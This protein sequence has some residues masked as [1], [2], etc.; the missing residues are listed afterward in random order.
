MNLRWHARFCLVLWMTVVAA[1]SPWTVAGHEGLHR[2]GLVVRH[3]DGRLTYVYVTYP[4]EEISGI[5]LLR[6][7]RLDLVTVGFGGLGEA[8]CELEGEGCS[9]GEC[10][11]N[12]C[13]GSRDAPYWQPCYQEAPGEWRVWR[14]G[15]SSARIHDGD[16][17][18]WS[19]G[20][21]E[22]G[23]PPATITDVAR[24]VGVADPPVAGSSGAALEPAARTLYPPGVEPVRE[25]PG[26]GLLAYLAALGLLALVGA[27]G[28]YAAGRARRRR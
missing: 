10:R 17:Y 22:A 26:E 23:P 1:L 28:V 11:K 25:R 20:G 6:R 18:G 7:S 13:Q 19:W 5:E 9:T 8:V 12:L 21:C 16:I 27:A 14:L 15:A 3:G 4:E 2:A 24:L